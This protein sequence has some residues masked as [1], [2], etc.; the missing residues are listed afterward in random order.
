M[1]YNQNNDQNNQFLFENPTRPIIPTENI[2]QVRQTELPNN[3]LNSYQSQ[4]NM[5]LNATFEKN[6]S[7]NFTENI[8]DVPNNQNSINNGIFSRPNTVELT[9][10]PVAEPKLET[11]QSIPVADDFSGV[12]TGKTLNKESVELIEKKNGEF[13]SG[14]ISPDQFYEDARKLMLANLENSYQRK[15]KS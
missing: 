14:K 1:D 15:I 10:P 9:M 2:P 12:K 5:A 4:G 13:T 6:P 7:Q 11:E 3:N 8:P